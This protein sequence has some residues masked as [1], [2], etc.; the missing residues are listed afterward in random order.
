MDGG[1]LRRPPR[2]FVALC[3]AVVWLAT[4]CPLCVPPD[5]AASTRRP[6]QQPG[7]LEPPSPPP[8]SDAPV[9]HRRTRSR[10]HQPLCEGRHCVNGPQR[11]DVP[12][13]VPLGFGGFVCVCLWCVSCV[14]G[15]F[16]AVR[17][18]GSETECVS[19]TRSDG[20]VGPVPPLTV[21][22]P[23]FP[24]FPSPC[25]SCAVHGCRSAHCLRR[26]L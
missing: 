13:D 7:A 24:S 25:S 21:L 12:S 1:A 5:C 19:S 26:R 11:R 4:G 23:L 20:G 18:N 17:K 9:G 22:P 3:G 2:T 16:F 15:V 8:S 6:S 10:P 14:L